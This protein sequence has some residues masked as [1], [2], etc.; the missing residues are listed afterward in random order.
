M[1]VRINKPLVGAIVLIGLVIF[2]LESMKSPDRGRGPVAGADIPVETALENQLGSG[3]AVAD[4]PAISCTGGSCTST[5]DAAPSGP[6]NSL[7]DVPIA[8]ERRQE[9]ADR[10]AEKT[11]KYERAKEI[12]DPHGFINL[13]A[14]KSDLT[15]AEL[16]GKKV[17]LVDFWTYSCINCQRTT[18]Y[19]NAWYEKYKDQGLEIIGVHTPEFSFEKDRENVVAAVKRLGI[20]YPVVLDNAYATW[21][22][23]RNRFWPRKY[24]IDIDGFIVYDHIGEGGYEETEEKIQAALAERADI[25]RTGT[26]IAG[27]TVNPA[28]GADLP[29]VGGSISPETYF[30]AARNGYFGNGASGVRGEQTLRYDPEQVLAHTLYLDGVWNITEEYAEN[31]SAGAKIAYR[32][33]AKNVYLVG[34]AAS[35]VRVRLYRDG[36]PLTAAEAGE[37]V[38][39]ESGEATVLIQE[40][41]LYKLIKE[42]AT[43]EHMLEMIIESSGLRAFTFTFG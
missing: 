10:I 17:V 28:L 40:D 37:D 13:P 36:K 8:D 35:P 19:L 5:A 26:L 24:L 38:R 31:K 23:Y 34:S 39:F 18:P 11:W 32:Y 29:P 6:A 14:G 9:I 3:D 42:A 15:V 22:A 27:G 7:L 30:G 41:R 21:S 20:A 1:N 43:G 16:V 2:V 4:G 25:L 12:M 33:R